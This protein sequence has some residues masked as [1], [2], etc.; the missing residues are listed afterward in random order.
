MRL[1]HPSRFFGVASDFTLL[2]LRPIT[3]RSLTVLLHLRLR[4]T[5]RKRSVPASVIPT[6][7]KTKGG[8]PAVEVDT[9]RGLKLRSQGLNWRDISAEVGVPRDT[10]IRHCEAQ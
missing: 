5:G 9:D 3:S 8:P 4:P 7:Q 6:L 2:F 1:P 10:L